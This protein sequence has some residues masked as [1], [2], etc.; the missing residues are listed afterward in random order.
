MSLL[1]K[2]KITLYHSTTNPIAGKWK[3]KGNNGYGIYLAKSLKYSKT[4]G[5]ITYKVIVIPKRTLIFNDN[6]V[7]GKGFFNMT[8][9]KYKEFIKNYDSLAWYRKGILQEFVVLDDK[10]IKDYYTI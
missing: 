7:R 3:M 1:L 8:E 6:E 5:D 10:I 9:I 2:N 4:F